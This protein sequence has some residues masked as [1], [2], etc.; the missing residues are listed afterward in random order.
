MSDR[1]SRLNV[2]FGY[3][4]VVLV[5]LCLND[6][7]QACIAAA[8]EGGNLRQ[9]LVTAE[10]FFSYHCQVAKQSKSVEDRADGHT[11]FIDR[12]QTVVRKLEVVAEA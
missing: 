12:L 10:V 3:L 4:A 6:D 1:E 5:C 9:L 11:A 8:L 7:A 2:A